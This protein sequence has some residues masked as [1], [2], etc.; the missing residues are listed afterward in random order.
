MKIQ[1]IFQ[2]NQKMIRWGKSGVFAILDQGLYSA[3]NFVLNVLLA[4]WLSSEEYGVFST[5]FLIYLLIYGFHNAI[6]LEPIS[7]LGTGKYADDL[8]QYLRSQYKIHFFMS[9]ICGLLIVLGAQILFTF[10][11]ISASIYSALLG[12]GLFLPL[13]LLLWLVRRMYYIWRKPQVSA[14]LSFVY[15]V[16]FGSVT[17]L[18][19]NSIG[20][21]GHL[22]LVYLIYGSASLIAFFVSLLSPARRVPPEKQNTTLTFS[23]LLREQ[24]K[25]GRWVASANIFSLLSSQ[26]QF[27]LV[28]ITLGIGG[29][30]VYRALQNVMTPMMQVIN[31]ISSL[32]LPSVSLGFGTSD[33]KYMKRIAFAVSGVLVMITGAYLVGLALFPATVE[34]LLYGG[35]FIEYRWL[36]PYFGIVPLV[37]SFGIGFSLINRSLQKPVYHTISAGIVALVGVVTA[38]RMISLWGIAGG[39]ASLISIQIV[40]L[41]VNI[42]IYRKWFA[43]KNPLTVEK[44]VFQ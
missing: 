6:L 15:A 30:G 4:R 9:G 1:P 33:R 44:D 26:I 38:P 42:V 18:I 11:L 17:L 31:A 22:F 16:V 23:H 37:L 8:D 40:S 12:V 20:F 5:S 21:Q 36:I 2:I 43:G 10:G 3:S 19:K 34:S 24:W 32:S 41:I 27:M 25:F 29:A 39:V 28:G 7:V 13:M 14:A 35:K